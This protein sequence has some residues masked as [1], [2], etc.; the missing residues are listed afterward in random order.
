MVAIFVVLRGDGVPAGVE[1][2][3]GSRGKG[4]G[5]SGQRAPRRR[6]RFARGKTAALGAAAGGFMPA[7]PQGTARS[8]LIY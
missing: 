8:S 3:V 4:V 7:A 5:H 6:Q 2:A 1:R